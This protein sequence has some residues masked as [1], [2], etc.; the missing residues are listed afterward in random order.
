MTLV[1]IIWQLLP[2]RW[3]KHLIRTFYNYVSSK[4]KDG[5]LTFLNY[6]YAPAT[7]QVDDTFNRE[8]AQ[9]YEE[10]ASAVP[11]A[12]KKVL[13]VS[14]G[15]GGGADYI[16]RANRPASL[17]G[18]DISSSAVAFCRARYR[19]PGL[20]FS[21]GDAN[22]LPF[23]P[24]QFDAVLNIE[25][26][27]NYGSLESFVAEIKRVLNPG[28]Y[29]LFADMRPVAAVPALRQQL[30]PPGM[31]IVTERNI[32]ANV[33]RALDINSSNTTAFVERM[34]F[35]PFR[36]FL[37]KFAGVQGTGIYNGLKAG[38]IQYWNFTVQRLEEKITSPSI[39]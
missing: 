27:H 9:L 8:R 36:G 30:S 24:Q 32:T 10:V 38:T 14:S 5:V 20:S 7:A 2:V 15:R 13:E 29:L 28:G 33:V 12:G 6:G 1:H 23:P 31:A 18:V 35:W 4:D 17:V 11:L 34:A 26:S 39:S 21:V 37:R 22:A 25:A 19:R 3:K 16:M